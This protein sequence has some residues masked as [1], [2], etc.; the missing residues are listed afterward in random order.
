M[1]PEA[2]LV[3]LG[4]GGVMPTRERATS[5]ILARLWNGLTLVLDAGE[6]AQVRLAEAGYS[7]HDID[8]IVLTHGHGDHVNGVPGLLQSM[9]V[10]KRERP[11]HIAGPPDALSF[12]SGVLEAWRG[13][14][15]FDVHYHLLAPGDRI[16]LASTGGDSVELEAFKTCHTRWSLGYRLT[17]KLR[18][19]VN[20]EALRRLGVRPGPW[21]SRLLE[22][23]PVQ[24]EGRV[25]HPADVLSGGGAYTIVYTGDTAPCTTTLEAARGAAVLLHDSTFSSDMEEEAVE[26]GHSTAG[27]AALVARESGAGLLVLIHVSPRYR[28][29]EARRLLEEASRVFPRTVLA[30]DLARIRVPMARGAPRPRTRASPL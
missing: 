10:S 2:T 16:L 30:W 21:L 25:I 4:S 29:V 27:H 20:G 9:S 19:R 12:V 24:V 18:P 6:G 17:V 7:T 28:G 14:L 22:G 26:R 23:E 15:G 1:P 5:S 11:L 3:V 8:Y 13:R